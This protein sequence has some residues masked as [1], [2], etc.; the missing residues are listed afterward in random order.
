MMRN[1]TFFSYFNGKE[2]EVG[3][4]G[5]YVFVLKTGML[6]VVRVCFWERENNEVGN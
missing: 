2:D 3:I 5:C 1:R 4:G 6:M